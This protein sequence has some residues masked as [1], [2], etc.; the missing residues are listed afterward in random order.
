MAFVQIIEFT[1]TRV[2]EVL[3]LMDEWVARTEG[4]RKTGR[5][6]FSADRE[7]A[8]TYV[9]VVEFPSYERAMENSALPETAEF[10]ER[11]NKLCDGPPSFRNLDVRRVDDLSCPGGSGQDELVSSTRS[12]GPQSPPCSSMSR[13]A[14]STTP[15]AIQATGRLQ[16]TRG[17]LSGPRPRSLPSRTHGLASG[18]RSARCL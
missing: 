4:K 13:A 7:K 5:S 1:T 8:N 11:L 14:S 15:G 17:S 12:S 3:D 18:R 2:D 9:Q 16:S 6:V 10:A